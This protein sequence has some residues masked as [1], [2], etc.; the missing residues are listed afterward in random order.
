[1][2]QLSKF[3]VIEETY[4]YENHDEKLAHIKVMQ[5]MGYSTVSNPFQTNDLAL[6]YQIRRLM[7]DVTRL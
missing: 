1:M 2:K 5:Y 3:N 6:T 7:D 4:L